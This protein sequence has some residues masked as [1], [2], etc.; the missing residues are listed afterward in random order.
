MTVTTRPLTVAVL[1]KQVP[2]FD[3]RQLDDDGRLARAG[4]DLEMN[5]YCRRAVSQAVRLARESAGTCVVITLGPPSAEDCLREAV[6]WGADSGVLVTDPVF[7]G[8][9]T[10]ATARALAAALATI[11]P[12]DLVVC[13]RNSVDADTAQLP[14]Q[15]AEL[16]DLPIA[17]GVRELTRVGDRLD[18]QCELDDGSMDCSVR[19]PAL[20]TCA[21]RLIA[22]AKVDLAGRAAVCPDRIRRLDAASLGAGPWGAAGSPTVVGSVRDLAVPRRRLRCD[23]DVDSQVR[24]AVAALAE[25]GAFDRPVAP[26]PQSVPEAHPAVLDQLGSGGAVVVLAEPGRDRATRELLGAAARLARGGPVVAVA[27]EPFDPAVAG[28]WGADLVV[29]VGG[30]VAE[31]DLAAAVGPWCADLSPWAVLAPSTMWGRQVAARL[32]ARLDAGLVADAIELA[33]DA[34]GRLVCGKPAFG[35]GLVAAITCRS[36]IQLATVRAGV[37]PVGRPRAAV[38]A[39]APELAATPRGRIVPGPRVRDDDPDVLAAAEVIVVAGA[40][41]DPRD[42]P[43]LRPLLDTLGAELAATRKVTDRGWQPR[44]R[45]V[46]ITG[47]SVAPRLFVALGVKGTTNHVLGARAAGSVLAVNTDP[48][49][50]VFDACDVGVVADWRQVVPRLVD[51][52]TD[53][54]VLAQSDS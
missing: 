45:Q 51:A 21:E 39:L 41:V 44:A 1:V 30:V 53:R 7:A 33:V 35:G 22:P 49:A 4:L 9:D 31:E 12:I 16:L 8:S 18:V 14:A 3:A 36:S 34:D 10:L 23:G 52:L 6:A 48:A 24:R 38:A 46:G 37:L 47:R 32:A 28:G 42:Y 43:L 27:T 5:P 13:G 20:I 11:G 25:A 54:A 17:A 15:L 29:P 19:L 50:P 40:G 2:R 26:P